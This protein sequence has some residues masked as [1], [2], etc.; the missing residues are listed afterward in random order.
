MM[1]CGKPSVVLLGM[2]GF[3]KAKAEQEAG[4]NSDSDSE[5]ELD[6][7]DSEIVAVLESTLIR[8]AGWAFTDGWGGMAGA[9]EDGRTPVGLKIGS[10]EESMVLIGVDP[11]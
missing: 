7:E 6:S 4:A 3:K 5:A 10:S 8:L 11:G 2:F 1:G 9:D